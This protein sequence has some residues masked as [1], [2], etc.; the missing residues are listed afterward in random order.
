MENIW[1]SKDKIDTKTS[2]VKV[3][4]K[5]SILDNLLET[6]KAEHFVWLLRH[7][8]TQANTSQDMRKEADELLLESEFWP[9]STIRK[10]A[11]NFLNFWIAL[12]ELC[13]HFDP[14]VTR[15]RQTAKVFCDE[16]WLAF[17][18]DKEL[19]DETIMKSTY[20]YLQLSKELATRE[21][22]NQEGTEIPI[23]WTTRNQNW[24]ESILSARLRIPNY[25]TKNIPSNPYKHHIMIG[26]RTGTNGFLDAKYNRSGTDLINDMKE[27]TP[28]QLDYGFLN[29]QLEFI[30][31][32]SQNYS[33]QWIIKVHDHNVF[34]FDTSKYLQQVEE[35][36][37]NISTLTILKW[38]NIIEDTNIVNAYLQQIR[39]DILN[40]SS[41][42]TI[43]YYL[44]NNTYIKPYVLSFLIEALTNPKSNN[45]MFE[46]IVA[47]YINDNDFSLEQKCRWLIDLYKS[48]HELWQYILHSL[49]TLDPNIIANSMLS[50]IIDEE[51]EKILLQNHDRIIPKTKIEIEI[52]KINSIK[53]YTDIHIDTLVKNNVLLNDMYIPQN[54]TR[55]WSDT[56]ISSDDLIYDILNNDKNIFT[57]QA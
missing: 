4:S 9:D 50:Q 49:Y 41:K 14:T 51:R 43:L 39:Q 19:E 2:I 47:D 37:N 26:H 20:P 40:N 24:A 23:L 57:I 53:N 36:K 29:H 54:L 12:D 32:K 56:D 34:E 25:I 16:I 17:P 21:K 42:E 6:K 11:Q 55:Q 45:T 13:I 38:N 48:H 31:Q 52:E 27:S 15:D 7:G 35:L 1:P 10:Q 8:L 3:F 30:N 44:Q 5:N 22:W 33:K 18:H 46:N 28:W